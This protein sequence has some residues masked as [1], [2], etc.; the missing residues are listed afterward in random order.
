[1][2]SLDDVDN[3]SSSRWPLPCYLSGSPLAVRPALRNLNLNVS[4]LAENS[5]ILIWYHFTT[6]PLYQDT[7]KKMLKKQQ[8]VF[9]KSLEIITEGRM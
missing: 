6:L 3:D 1:M 9:A 4:S 8:R 7:G 5:L 2:V